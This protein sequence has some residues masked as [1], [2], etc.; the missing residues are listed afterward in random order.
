MENIIVQKSKAFAEYCKKNKETIAKILVG[1]ETYKTAVDEIQ[2][3]ILALE[4]MNKQ[5]QHFSR[6]DLESGCVYLPKNQPFYS[7][8]LFAIVPSFFCD[9]V[10][11]RPPVL[12]REVFYK[13]QEIFEKFFS[14]IEF[15][16]DS[17]KHFLNNYSSK[18][19]VV[20]YT[21]KHENASE[22]LSLLPKETLFIFNGGGCN[23]IVVT[24]SC[25]LTENVMKKIVSA[26]LYN[27]GQDCMAPSVI[28]VDKK[29]RNEFVDK[30]VSLL[31]K[32]VVGENSNPKTDV[33]PLLDELDENAI[34]ELI[35]GASDC[36]Y[37]KGY[38][39]ESN[40]FNPLVLEFDTI[41]KLPYQE[42][43]MPIFS[44]LS[45][46]EIS[47]VEKYLSTDWAINNSTY[48]SIFS[49]E[50]IDVELGRFIVIQN[51]TLDSVDNGY[52]EFGGYGINSS[53]YSID[54]KIYPQPILVSR[55]IN[56]Y[57]K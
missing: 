37:N 36:I 50:K 43:Y 22:L 46:N 51:D 41:E 10:Y 1:A 47:Q 25:D 40:I 17:R 38:N 2:R 45:Y 32:T 54:G 27:S 31:G 55:E 35:S 52:T 56:K 5:I 12:L 6:N 23:P 7:I 16:Y 57:A 11:V 4:D 49:N 19:N 42:H 14:N 13:L 48:I 39:L 53:Y 18:A 8:V 44:I 24:E 28:F 26:Q 9:R 3:G 20:I 21:G 34:R 29:K 30:L 15:C 33:G